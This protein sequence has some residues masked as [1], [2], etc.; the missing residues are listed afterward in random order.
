MK[1]LILI[2]LVALFS[3]CE[4]NVV[5]EKD[6]VNFELNDLQGTYRVNYDMFKASG[7]NIYD[8]STLVN[9][10]DTFELKILA[11]SSKLTFRSLSGNKSFQFDAST[12]S[13]PFKLK[14][15]KQ[16]TIKMWGY[17]TPYKGS[18][19]TNN[20]AW[21]VFPYVNPYI[22]EENAPV[23]WCGFTKNTGGKVSLSGATVDINQGQY[24][25]RSA[26]GSDY[27]GGVEWHFIFK[28]GDK[29]N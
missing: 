16:V 14:K 22:I 17:D 11:D 26:T 24:H 19:N 6:M 13:I 29:L 1:K 8:L 3:H 21:K 23:I 18:I 5:N 4:K 10:T 27:N 28:S 12:K 2:S 15:Y 9:R 25:L 7:V 20:V